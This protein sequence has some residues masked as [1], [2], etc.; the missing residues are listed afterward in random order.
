MSRTQVYKWHKRF[1]SGRDNVEDDLNPGHPTT[2]RN[3]KNIQNVNELVHK[4][5][6]MTVRMLAEELGLGRTILTEDLREDGA[7]IALR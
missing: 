3:D 1:R 5:R 7:L 2:S 6:R 4:D